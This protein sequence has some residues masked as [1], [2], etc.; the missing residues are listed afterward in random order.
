M[1]ALVCTN[2]IQID[3]SKDNGRC[4]F[5]VELAWDGVSTPTTGCDGV[6]SRVFFDNTQGSKTFYA[7]L[8]QTKI[9]PAVYRIDPGATRNI[10]SRAVLHAA[11]LDD[12]SDILGEGLDLNEVPPGAGETLLN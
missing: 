6:V 8:F 10:T 11:G 4:R 5:L 1:P 3:L 2:P 7:H 12:R 9:G